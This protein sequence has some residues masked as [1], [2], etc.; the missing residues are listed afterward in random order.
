MLWYIAGHIL[1][2]IT[3]PLPPEWIQSST[4]ANSA[5]TFRRIRDTNPSAPSSPPSK[6]KL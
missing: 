4:R 5:K 3:S 6:H 1:Q 2:Y